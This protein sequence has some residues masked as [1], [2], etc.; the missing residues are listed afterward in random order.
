MN[1]MLVGGRLSFEKFNELR[2]DLIRR[3]VH[4]PTAGASRYARGF[5]E[6]ERRLAAEVV[7]S[8]IS[9]GGFSKHG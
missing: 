8:H 2:N 1:L 4:E 3:F 7:Y 9:G 6:L 5:E